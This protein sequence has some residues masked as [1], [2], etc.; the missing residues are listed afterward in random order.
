MNHQY[1]K[2]YRRQ[3]SRESKNLIKE[4]K[5][6]GWMFGF[7]IIAIY[8]CFFGCTS[9]PGVGFGLPAVS[10]TKHEIELA[11]GDTIIIEYHTH[12]DTLIVMEPK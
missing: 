10:T 1:W 11:V 6:D 12:F 2:D 9:T 8:L 4:L 5:E 7:L 3:I